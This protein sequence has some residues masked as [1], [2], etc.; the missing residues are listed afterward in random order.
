MSVLDTRIP[1]E[2]A[3]VLKYYVYALRDPRD[4]RVFCVGKGKADRIN[5]H[6]GEAA[7]DPHSERAKHIKIHEIEVSGAAVDL[8]FLRTEIDDE[9]T[10]YVVE[11]AVIDAFAV[12]GHPLTNL[13]RGAYRI[14]SW[15]RSQ[16]PW[17]KGKN[18][19]GFNGEPAEELAHVV[20][21]HMRD[22]FRNQVMYRRFL[23]GYEG[24]VD[25]APSPV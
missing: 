13:V 10:A 24:S 4:G 15:F 18:R 6:V 25:A 3:E 5:S 22:A 17:D 21:T 19:W 14:D 9:A 16:M 23:N 7:A 2:V 20:G 1:S 8:L 12:D 11:Q